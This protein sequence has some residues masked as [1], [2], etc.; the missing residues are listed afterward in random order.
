MVEV[1]SGLASGERYVESPHEGL[2]DGR[3]VVAR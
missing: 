1:L 3:K 2:V